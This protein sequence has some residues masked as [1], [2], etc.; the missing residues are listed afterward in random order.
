METLKKIL[1]QIRAAE[2]KFNRPPGSVQLL[3]VS[4]NRSVESI[5]ATVANGQQAF[6][7][8]YLQEAL[9]KISVLS[10]LNLEWHFIG[11]LQANKTRQV[12]ENFSWVQSINRFKI[13]ERLSQQRPVHL[14]PL[15]VCLEI[16]ISNEASKSGLAVTAVEDLAAQI[17]NLPNLKLRG[18]MVIPELTNDFQKQRLIYHQVFLLQQ[19]MNY[20]RF[21]F[22][23]LVYGN[24]P[25]LH[26][27]YC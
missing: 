18:L 17:Q 27:C 13:A 14:P 11:S 4:K 19:K 3:A 12:A 25:R 15:N 20:C 6:G 10:A 1:V 9:P 22:R 24:I 7:E 26:S 23:H 5:R 16:N 8:N 21:Q 2:E